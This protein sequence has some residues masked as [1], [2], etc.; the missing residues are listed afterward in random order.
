VRRVSFAFAISS[1]LVWAGSSCSS[2]AATAVM[3]PRLAAVIAF[4]SPPK[5]F[6]GAAAWLELSLYRRSGDLLVGME[7]DPA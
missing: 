4:F 5:A 2:E 7:E 3:Y 6:G 1:L